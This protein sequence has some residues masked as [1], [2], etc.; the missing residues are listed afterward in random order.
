MTNLSFLPYVGPT[1]PASAVR[2]L[3]LGESH[4]LGDGDELPRDPLLATR[5]VV[6]K[7]KSREW[8]IR[9]LTIG[10][11]VITGQQAWEIDR[12]TVFDAIAFANMVQ[13]IMPTLRHRPTVEQARASW[14]AF[15]E[16]LDRWDPT[17]V[18]A[19]GR[20]FLWDNMPA[21][22][23]RTAEVAFG[24][25]LLPMREFRTPSGF[26][27]TVVI[28]HLSRASAPRWQGPIREF[29]AG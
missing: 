5:T 22:D 17:H 18:V 6:E 25:A 23:R 15:R 26:A 27:S 13:T 8:A 28:P 3:L 20:R 21:S 9:Y 14:P 12:T 7:W 16:V 11:R 1:F 29:L 10:A 24:G 2:L 4:Y 19:T